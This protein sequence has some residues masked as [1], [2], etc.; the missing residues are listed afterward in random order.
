MKRHIVLFL[1]LCTLLSAETKHKHLEYSQISSL[2]KSV[3]DKAIVLGNGNKDVYVFIDPL[4]RYSRKFIKTVST[5]KVMLHKYRYHLFLYEIPRLHSQQT[6]Y[7]IYHDKKPLNALLD[8]ML[9]NEQ[10]VS[11]KMEDLENERKIV[12]DIEKVAKELD[13]FKR[14]YIIVSQESE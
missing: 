11:S 5:H 13:V 3:D 4:C 8:V 7:A 1:V 6:I 12:S 10:P 14:P 2:V 9:E